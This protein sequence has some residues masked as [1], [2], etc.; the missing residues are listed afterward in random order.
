MYHKMYQHNSGTKSTLFSYFSSIIVFF[1]ETATEQKYLN[2]L[3]HMFNVLI[4]D[5]DKIE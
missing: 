2:F 4:M 1:Q 3:Y 5:T